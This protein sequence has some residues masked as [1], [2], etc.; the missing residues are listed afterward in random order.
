MM[1]MMQERIFFSLNGEDLSTYGVII[2]IISF[3]IGISSQWSD[4]PF[5]LHF[6]KEDLLQ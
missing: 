6:N 5:G 3:G 4:D 2:I 1:M